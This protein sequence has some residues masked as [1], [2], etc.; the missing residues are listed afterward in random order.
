MLAIC[1]IDNSLYL[2]VIM[3]VT[4]AQRFEPQDGRF[5]N[6][7]YHTGFRCRNQ[8]WYSGTKELTGLTRRASRSSSPSSVMEY[9]DLAQASLAIQLKEPAGS[10]I[11]VARIT[12]RATWRLAMITTTRALL[13]ATRSSATRVAWN[14]QEGKGRVIVAVFFEYD[15]CLK[16][17]EMNHIK[18]VMDKTSKTKGR[19]I[20]A[21][22]FDFDSCLK[23]TRWK[24]KS[25]CC[26]C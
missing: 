18:N 6:D 2:D 9:T 20:A 13:C 17:A 23:W 8:S 24:K 14:G 1:Y 4:L 12:D 15:R 16:W 11:P 25:Y 19:V 7:D 5:R 22:L 21:V 3:S 10:S 26:Y